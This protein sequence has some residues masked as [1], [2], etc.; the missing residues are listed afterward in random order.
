VL[1]RLRPTAYFN[2]RLLQRLREDS[3]V[4]IPSYSH[5]E[6]SW[7]VRRYLTALLLP[8][9][10]TDASSPSPSSSSGLKVVASMSFSR[11]CG[12]SDGGF[13]WRMDEFVDLLV[14]SAQGVSVVAGGILDLVWAEVMLA[15]SLLR[16]RSIG[17]RET[18]Q[19]WI[20]YFRN[21]ALLLDNVVRR[22]TLCADS[23]AML[24]AL[25][26]HVLML[27]SSCDGTFFPT[28]GFQTEL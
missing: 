28:F 24:L 26:N 6:T 20:C 18:H 21:L 1:E 15:E 4:H 2:E 3:D 5:H 16:V 27:L 9:L 17:P 13:V 7:L 8:L 23:K 22:E 12:A 19:Q 14:E 10:P 25:Q 11:L